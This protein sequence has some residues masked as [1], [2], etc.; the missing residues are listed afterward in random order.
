M[1]KWYRKQVLGLEEFLRKTR[2]TFGY[3]EKLDTSFGKWD[4][5]M[6]SAVVSNEKFIVVAHRNRGNIGEFDFDVIS[7]DRLITQISED[8]IF[9]TLYQLR[10][11]PLELKEFEKSTNLKSKNFITSRLT[12][13][14]YYI[15]YLNVQNENIRFDENDMRKWIISINPNGSSLYMIR[16]KD[17]TIRYYDG[18]QM[19][20]LFC[21]KLFTESTEVLMDDLHDFGCIEKAYNYCSDEWKNSKD[22]L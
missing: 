14:G 17:G 21:P 8:D 2:S 5:R 6:Y 22:L 13:S 10:N 7:S 18:G 16:Y 9:S 4:S 1:A 3:A 12:N 11:E 19:V 20:P 15:N